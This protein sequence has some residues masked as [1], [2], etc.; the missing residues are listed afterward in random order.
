MINSYLT[1]K[2]GQEIFA[3]NV[4]K[5][6]SILEMTKI[7]K[8]PK[9][10]DYI[11]GIINLRGAVLPL[12]DTRV[13]FLMSPSE[14]TGNTCV[15]VLEITKH[16]EVV[17]LG[18]MVDAVLEVI[19]INNNDIQPPP[20]IG[21]KDNNEF[22]EGMVNVEDDFIMILDMDK[23]FSTDEFIKLKES[24]VTKEDNVIV[25]QESEE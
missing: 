17:K 11:K 23:I 16:E 20:S 8:I 21:K 18:A 7:T 24:T 10:P 19:E 4:D 3:A 15:L 2:L 5:V 13:K 9:A 25:R 14:I 6:L 12:I 22:I 1:F